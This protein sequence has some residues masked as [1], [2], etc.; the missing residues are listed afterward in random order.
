MYSPQSG[1]PPG[2]QKRGL[3]TMRYAQDRSV[4]ECG[5]SLSRSNSCVDPPAVHE[6]NAGSNPQTRR[7]DRKLA[8]AEST[9]ACV[10][11]SA[12]SDAPC[13]PLRGFPHNFGSALPGQDQSACGT[14][15][16]IGC[17]QWREPLPPALL[18][19]NRKAALAA[20]PAA[21]GSYC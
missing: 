15:S 14:S 17:G 6:K 1:G 2:G 4:P 5:E 19:V 7:P 9:V 10:P 21:T 11:A 18:P 16:P 20:A 3:F 8:R 12:A 13:P